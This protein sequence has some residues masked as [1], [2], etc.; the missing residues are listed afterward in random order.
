MA[1][2]VRAQPALMECGSASYYQ[3]VAIAVQPRQ[4][5]RT[6]AHGSSRGKTALTPPSAPL[7][8][9]AGEG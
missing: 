5:R 3:L 8:R 6:V 9:T 2:P 4:G 1:S 7:S